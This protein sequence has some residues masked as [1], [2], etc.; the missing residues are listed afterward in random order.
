[1]STSLTNQKKF[2]K[3]FIEREKTWDSEPILALRTDDCTYDILPKGLNFPLMHKEETR[4][5][6]DHFKPIWQDY[7]VRLLQLEVPTFLNLTLM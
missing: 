7:K 4:G 6:Y 3:E 5:F 1:M 2:A